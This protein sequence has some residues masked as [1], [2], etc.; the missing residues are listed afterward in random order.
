MTYLGTLV[1]ILNQCNIRWLIFFPS[2]HDQKRYYSVEVNTHTD[3]GEGTTLI[4]TE[5]GDVI[6][7]IAAP[8]ARR[9]GLPIQRF[10]PLLIHTM[11]NQMNW[12]RNYE[13]IWI[14]RCLR[15]H[16]QNE[17]STFVYRFSKKLSFSPSFC[18]PHFFPFHLLWFSNKQ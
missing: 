5:L 10:P 8:N 9:Y 6:E 7:T 4:D 14:Y 18:S 17:C 16:Q 1:P 11:V 15:V 2:S 3:S 13:F 12:M